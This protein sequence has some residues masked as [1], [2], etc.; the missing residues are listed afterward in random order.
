MVS[1]TCPLRVR[2]RLSSQLIGLLNLSSSSADDCLDFLLLWKLKVG[3]IYFKHQAGVF[4][5]SD[6]NSVVLR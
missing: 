1:S 5:L 4:C 3:V 6:C 2:Y